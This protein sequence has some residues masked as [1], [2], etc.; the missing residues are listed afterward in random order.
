MEESAMK[1]LEEF[2]VELRNSQT[3]K[4][5]P[6]TARKVSA[7]AR[8]AESIARLHLSKTV[9]NEHASLAIKLVVHSLR[10]VGIDPDTG[11]LDASIIESGLSTSQH[12][13]FML[14]K[15]ALR[16]LTGDGREEVSQDAVVAYAHGE[17][18][19]EERHITHVLSILAN[20]GDIYEP[21]EGRIALVT[22]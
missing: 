9:T 6:V 14:V 10:D 3:H 7:M 15:E 11:M 2:Y 5:I 22:S 20:R 8:L 16:V 18:N 17:L 19:V 12:E 1:L 13:R 4:S 21:S